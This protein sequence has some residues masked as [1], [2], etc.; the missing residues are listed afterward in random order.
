MKP[1]ILYHDGDVLT[2]VS[3]DDGT[4]LFWNDDSPVVIAF[5]G[6]EP[7]LY[8]VGSVPEIEDLFADPACLYEL[9]EQRMDPVREQ[10]VRMV[11]GNE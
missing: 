3:F 9:P 4:W 6:T 1:L 5:P 8:E 2:C 11:L 10:Y 7:E